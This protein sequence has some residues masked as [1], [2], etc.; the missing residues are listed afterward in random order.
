MFSDGEGCKAAQGL[1]SEVT[2]DPLQCIDHDENTGM[3]TPRIECYD[4]SV[5]LPSDSH[6]Q[7]HSLTTISVT[8]HVLHARWTVLGILVDSKMN[9]K[10]S[11]FI[12]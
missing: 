6:F 9:E 12:G 2:Q 4:H 3:L 10:A 11:H 5:T 1:V 8:E 7:V